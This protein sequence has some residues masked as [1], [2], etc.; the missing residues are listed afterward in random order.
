M[1]AFTIL[2]LMFGLFFVL[3]LPVIMTDSD[4]DI[5]YTNRARSR[6]TRTRS[7]S[8]PVGKRKPRPASKLQTNEIDGNICWQSGLPKHDCP[9]G[10]CRT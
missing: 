5:Q 6:E 4:G 3:F 10:S 8:R 7:T 1:G 9:C 2:G